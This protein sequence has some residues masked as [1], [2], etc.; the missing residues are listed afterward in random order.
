M[1]LRAVA[2]VVTYGAAVLAA[3]TA[4]AVTYAPAMTIFAVLTVVELVLI[5]VLAAVVADLN[6][7]A[8]VALVAVRTEGRHRRCVSSRPFLHA[9]RC[10]AKAGSR[11]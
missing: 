10:G 8:V 5:G 3:V 11:L 1:T 7:L 4:R 6:V 2:T 9:A